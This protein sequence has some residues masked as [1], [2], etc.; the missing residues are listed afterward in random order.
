MA[1]QNKSNNAQERAELEPN[2]QQKNEQQK[3]TKCSKRETHTGSNLAQRINPLSL[4]QPHQTD[5]DTMRSH[6]QLSNS[7]SI[8]LHERYT[9]AQS[10]KRNKKWD[11]KS[12]GICITVQFSCRPHKRCSEAMENCIAWRVS[13]DLVCRGRIVVTV[14]RCAMPKCSGS[15]QDVYPLSLSTLNRQSVQRGH[16]MAK[17]NTFCRTECIA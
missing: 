16:G 11:H 14:Y 8:W 6:D 5:G 2:Q 9:R 7:R 15:E 3:H 12:E 4:Y 1:N 13:R 17:S 10:G